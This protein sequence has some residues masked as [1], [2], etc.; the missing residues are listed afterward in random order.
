ML[1]VNKELDKPLQVAVQAR[2]TMTSDEKGEGRN[3]S[4]RFG[5]TAFEWVQRAAR[6][7]RLSVSMVVRLAV[8]QAMERGDLF[9]ALA[10]P[11]KSADRRRVTRAA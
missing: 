11:P 2:S 8:D 7:N 5:P 1:K 3:V 4:V 9:S 6:L 10:T